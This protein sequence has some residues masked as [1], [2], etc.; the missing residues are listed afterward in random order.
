[1]PDIE[2]GVF[3][4]L[5][6][7]ASTT[8]TTAGTYYPISGVFLN[9]PLAN[10]KVVD[11]PGIKFVGVGCDGC[12]WMEIDWHATVQTDDNETTVQI[13]IKKNELLLE[14]SIMGTF[15]KVKDE[16]QALSGTCVLDLKSGDVIQLAI[17]SDDDG[18]VITLNN[19]TTSIRTFFK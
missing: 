11:D 9:S 5:D 13:G 15:L 8:I 17:T 10:F 3:A 1:M 4:A 14:T 7:P 6:V 19:F 18:G 16:A 2:T 12:M